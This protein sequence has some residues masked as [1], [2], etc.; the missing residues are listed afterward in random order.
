MFKMSIMRKGDH[1]LK[2]WMAHTRFDQ[3]RQH[4]LKLQN[5]TKKK[6]EHD[7]DDA[8]GFDPRENGEDEYDDGNQLVVDLP[9][10]LMVAFTTKSRSNIIKTAKS[11]F[12]AV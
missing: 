9:T 4:A 8:N 10:S 12:H 1:E 7:G 2:H 6:C 3:V 11:M 5:M